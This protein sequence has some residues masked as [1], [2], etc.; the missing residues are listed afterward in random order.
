L[1]RLFKIWDRHGD[2]T[3]RQV[4]ENSIVQRGSE[5]QTPREPTSPAGLPE[6]AAAVEIKPV[7]F[8]LD[9]RDRRWKSSAPLKWVILIALGFI[10]ILLCAS[11]W[12]VFTARQVAIRIEPEPDRISIRGGLAAP[13]IGPYFLLRPGEYILQADKACFRSLEK[14]FTVTDAKSQQ[15]SF[16]MT[17]LPGRLSV[18]AHRSDHPS[19]QLEGALVWID[20]KEVGRTPISELEVMAGR[21]DIEVRAENYQVF[22]TELEIEGCAAVQALDLALAPGWS[23]VTIH[24]D[25]EGALVRIDG[26]NVGTTPLKIELLM[27]AHDLEV[28]ADGFKA[29]RTHLAVTA[30]QPQVLET[31]RLQP[32]DPAMAGLTV[33]TEPAG[34]HVM[35]GDRFAGQTPL[36]LTLAPD[37]THMI[38]ISK[39]GYEKTARSVKLR[40]DDSKTL[41]VTLKPQLGVIHLKVEPPDAEIRV[42]GKSM[43][44]APRQLQLV[45]VEHQ[46]EIVKEGYQTHRTRITPQPGFE[47]EIKVS[48]NKLAALEKTAAAI[49]T[50]DNG[51]QLRLIPVQGFTMGSSRR[52]QGRRSN[53]TLRSIELRRP[54]YMGVREVTNKEFRQFLAAHHSGTFNGVSLNGDEFAVVQVTWEQA[55]LFCNWLSARAS[56]PPAY[57]I[58][59]ESPV[60]V[61]PMG[62]GYRLPTETE[63]EYCARFNNAQDPLKYS[64][65]NMFPPP[66]LAGNFADV[67]AKD[68]L[69]SY[70][71]GYNDGYPVT[72]PPAKF[73][74]NALGLYDLGGNAAE[75]CHDYYAIYSYEAGKV[76]T[77]PMGPEHGQHHV[78][79]GSSW[80][81]A[82]IGDLRLA[83]R[84]YSNGKRPDLGFRICR[85]L[86]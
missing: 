82:G 25:P 40:S 65:G 23:E 19:L 77:D 80:K 3:V 47:Q 85:Y 32:A 6:K 55:A 49:I 30:N 35:V 51:Y 43:G 8:R 16:P 64:W 31:V 62:T 36:E 14:R 34:A 27:G 79:K 61:E 54:F 70:L 72:A 37:T 58:R 53:E 1:T 41:T 38:H 66:T 28:S 74:V 50:A 59:G 15:L 10:L 60:P 33:R 21:R 71:E 73:K 18:Q 11:A 76:Y 86:N 81:S 42:D 7:P 26:K 84:D 67:S 63:W 45:A 52:E 78:I 46:L 83:F 4:E 39:A 5:G 44:V 9:R 2:R 22:H 20:G 24:S 56:L 48:L 17:Q 13:S 57:V 68:L 69:A 75:W 12:F 29:W